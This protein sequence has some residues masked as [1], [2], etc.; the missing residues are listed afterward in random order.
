MWGKTVDNVHEMDVALSNGRPARLG[1]LDGSQL[2]SMMRSGG[3]EGDIHRRLFEIGEANRDEIIARYPK[4]QRRVSG[5]NLD[6]FVGGMGF[7]MARFVVGSEGTLVTITEAK[8]KLV[9]RPKVTGLGV[10]HCH[11]LIEST[12][13]DRSGS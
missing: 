13:R 1:A 3:L 6:E 7:N 8:L 4:I 10:L 5:Y 11:D 9:D 2:E 12:G